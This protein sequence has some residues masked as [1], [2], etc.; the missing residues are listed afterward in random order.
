VLPSSRPETRKDAAKIFFGDDACQKAQALD[1]MQQSG[2]VV[3]LTWGGNSW[4]VIVSIVAL[5]VCRYHM[6]ILYSV[7]V[8][9]ARNN[10]AGPV[11]TIAQGIDVLLRADIDTALSL[12]DL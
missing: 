12:A 9:V 11:G 4:Q 5:E 6:Q 1:V 8:V 3:P 2:A 10:M 7:T